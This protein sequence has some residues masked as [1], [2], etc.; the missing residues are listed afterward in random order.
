M[1]AKRAA[2]IAGNGDGTATVGG[3]SRQGK[4][5]KGVSAK[6]VCKRF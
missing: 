6:F 1:F 2:Y 5:A 3:V 4:E